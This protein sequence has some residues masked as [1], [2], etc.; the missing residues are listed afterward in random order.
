MKLKKSNHSNKRLENIVKEQN[1][2]KNQ[3]RKKVLQQENSTFLLNDCLE[4]M[5]TTE[6]FKS[7]KI[8]ILYFTGT[9]YG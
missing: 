9:L 4:L 3:L 1:V 5:N 6:K 2:V 7:T 8:L